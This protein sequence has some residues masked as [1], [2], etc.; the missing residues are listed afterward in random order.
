MSEAGTGC[1]FG[2]RPRAP[3]SRASYLPH[4]WVFTRGRAQLALLLS[5]WCWLP[6]ACGCVTLGR[7]G[8][9]W[10]Q[11][12]SLHAVPHLGLSELLRVEAS[13]VGP[14][15]GEEQADRCWSPL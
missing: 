6:R 9:G 8:P 11:L 1:S 15:L 13:Q 10:P 2:P 4:G 7:A 14:D 12:G 5:P 3:G